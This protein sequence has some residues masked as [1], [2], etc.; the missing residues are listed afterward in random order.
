MF[1]FMVMFMFMGINVVFVGVC[2]KNGGYVVVDFDGVWKVLAL[3]FYNSTNQ[4]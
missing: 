1:G 4:W 2:Y 3:F